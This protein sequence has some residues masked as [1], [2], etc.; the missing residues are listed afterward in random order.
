M[1]TTDPCGTGKA[2]TGA[3][4]ADA[5]SGTKTCVSTSSSSSLAQLDVGDV[6]TPNSDNDPCGTGKACTGAKKADAASGTKT[7]VS[8]GNLAQLEVGDVCTPNSDNDP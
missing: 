7:C 3:K 4:K 1:G 5:A 6:C 8:T 2:C